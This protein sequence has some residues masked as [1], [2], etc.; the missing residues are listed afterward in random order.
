MKASQRIALL[1]GAC[2]LALVLTAQTKPDSSQVEYG[3]YIVEEVSRCQE[4]HT[5][6]LANGEYDK[7]KWMK[8]ATLEYG[9]LTPSKDWHKDAPDITGT[10]KL[11]TRWNDDG[12]RNFMKTALNPRGHKA[13][14]PMPQYHMQQKEA[15]AVT[16]YLKTLK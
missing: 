15:D 3:K 14:A 9:P 2:T 1:T 6:K 13:D 12:V 11:W 5:P 4:C 7:S 10:S 8:G 16:A